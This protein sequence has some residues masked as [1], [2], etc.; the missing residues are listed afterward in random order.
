MTGRTKA[1][2]PLFLAGSILALSGGC[3]SKQPPQ[4]MPAQDNSQALQEMEAAR[5]K[6][7]QE[8][9][10]ARLEAERAREEADRVKRVFRDGLNK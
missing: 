10:Q 3:A 2:I 1:L 9:A 5:L 6:A 7:E 4:E 8:A